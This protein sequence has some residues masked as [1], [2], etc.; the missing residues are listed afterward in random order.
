MIEKYPIC[1]QRIRQVP[2]QF[3]WVDQCLVRERYIEHC[4]HQG[5][6]L[7]LFLVTVADCQGLSYY[8]DPS[9]MKRLSMDQFTLEQARQNLIQL[10]LIAYKKPL[11]QVLALEANPRSTSKPRVSMDQP[12]AIGRIFKQIIGETS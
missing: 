8:S 5:A 4:S 10:G 3:S 6:A 2:K 7:Y 11:Y 9:I 1:P 12:L